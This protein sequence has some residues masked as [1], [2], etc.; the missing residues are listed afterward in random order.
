[1]FKP[2][3]SIGF[4]I[5]M[6]GFLHGY[7]NNFYKI[8]EVCITWTSTSSGIDYAYTRSFFPDSNMLN[9]NDNTFKLYA[10]PVRCLKN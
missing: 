8:G 7:D 5:L 4:D 6:T 2:G 3:G 1:M 10:L 9:R